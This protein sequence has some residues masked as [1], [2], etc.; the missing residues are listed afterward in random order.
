VTTQIH[1]RDR[2]SV[3]FTCLSILSQAWESDAGA[4]RRDHRIAT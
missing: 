2:S 1:P 3:Q 4:H